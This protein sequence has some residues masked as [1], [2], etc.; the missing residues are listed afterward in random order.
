[1]ATVWIPSILQE[2]TQGQT[3]VD[4]P[5]SNVRQVIQNLEAAYPGLKDGL[6]EDGSLRPDIA[7]AVDG[8]LT[9]LGLLET[10]KE[11]SEVQFMPAIAGG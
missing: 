11:D 4:V 3:T 7:V 10:V 6:M 5:G 2:L 8:E 1:V 9:R